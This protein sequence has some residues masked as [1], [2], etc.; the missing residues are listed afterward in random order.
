MRRTL[1]VVQPQR[2]GR[3]VWPP[4]LALLFY[5]PSDHGSIVIVQ[6]YVPGLS[7]FEVRFTGSVTPVG[8]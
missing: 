6:V 5:P 1:L 2:K 7:P 4:L 8:G 3:P